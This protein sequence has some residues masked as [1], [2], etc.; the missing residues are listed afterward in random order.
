M[1]KQESVEKLVE[2]I[3]ELKPL[4]KAAD[5]ADNLLHK[6]SQLTGQIDHMEYK[7]RESLLKIKEIDPDL[8]GE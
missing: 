6:I 4:L 8:F 2:I 1:N 3:S 7:L 5:D